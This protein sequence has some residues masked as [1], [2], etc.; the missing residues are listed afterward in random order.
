MSVINTYLLGYCRLI[1]LRTLIEV[2]AV[3]FGIL[4][5]IY[6]SQ[7]SI[8]RVSVLVVGSIFLLIAFRR[9]VLGVL[10][11]ILSTSAIL[12]V[13]AV[14]IRDAVTASDMILLTLALSYALR[15]AFGLPHNPLKSPLTPSFVAALA[16]V[17]LVALQSV[18]HFDIRPGMVFA[19]GRG[20]VYYAF[21]LLVLG[22]ISKPADVR[23]LTRS[24]L[25]IGI[26]VSLMMVAQVFIVPGIR[27]FLGSEASVRISVS[28]E[29]F[30]L[31]TP[32]WPVV[33]F[34]FFYSISRASIGKQLGNRRTMLLIALIC[35]IGLILSM[36]RII[37][38]GCISALV[39]CALFYFRKFGAKIVVSVFTAGASLLLVLALGLILLWSVGQQR[40]GMFEAAAARFF[41]IFEATEYETGSSVDYR[42][43]EYEDMK[44]YL[45]KH[46]VSGFGFGH[47]YRPFWNQQ[48][49]T[50]VISGYYVHNGVLA[51]LLPM[52]LG[53]LVVFFWLFYSGLRYCARKLHHVNDPFAKSLVLATFLTIIAMVVTLTT[54]P[55]LSDTDAVP[56]VA[57][58]L[59]L[60]VLTVR[61]AE[62]ARSL[63]QDGGRIPPRIRIYRRNGGQTRV[64]VTHLNRRFCTE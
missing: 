43:Q 28:E 26:V 1:K 53:G 3:L 30:R 18:L 48:T 38:L 10:A 50:Y 12:H 8:S 33:T 23:F 29:G 62:R 44:P 58:I 11:M 45:Q 56:V 20:Y 63:P 49:Q 7:L 46:F 39:G 57:L 51:I 9:P 6:F 61:Q 2:F 24:L 21:F 32:G 60:T 22:L 40:A 14:R 31:I 36:T 17:V 35:S 42:W 59:G 27:L 37:W 25:A 4:F 52:G 47:P 5:G 15:R 19:A 41:S 16:M 13:D 34:C 55:T 64:P 54:Q